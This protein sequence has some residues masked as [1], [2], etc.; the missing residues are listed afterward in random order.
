M[1]GMLLDVITHDI[2]NPAGVISGMMEIMEA[3]SPEDEMVDIIAGSARSLMNIID[4][5]AGLVQAS[6]GESI[7]KETLNLT[8]MIQSIGSEFTMLFRS[9]NLTL[10]YEISEN[11]LVQ[12]NPI[13]GEV[14]R[15]YLSNAA[16][17]AVAGKRIIIHTKEEPDSI[18]VIVKDNGETIPEEKRSIIFDRS[19]QLAN[20]IKRGRGLGLSIVKKIIEAHGGEAGVIPNEP[21][22]NSFYFQIPRSAN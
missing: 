15:N 14:I 17:Y 21:Q 12:G 7:E 9:N 19:Q 6:M 8:E 1:K 13:L 22:G 2:K 16:K 11:L 20:G 10:E 4:S 18:R 5:A 3:E